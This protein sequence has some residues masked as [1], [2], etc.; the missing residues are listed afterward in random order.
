MYPKKNNAEIGCT[1]AI[2]SAQRLIISAIVYLQA[3]PWVCPTLCS[4]RVAVVCILETIV[5]AVML[6]CISST[7]YKDRCPDFN[8]NHGHVNRC[9]SAFGYGGEDCEP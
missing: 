4:C 7:E 9:W 6:I 5:A 3:L 1:A 8:N 2:L